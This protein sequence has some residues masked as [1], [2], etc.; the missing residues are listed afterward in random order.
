MA[1]S[2]G[3]EEKREQWKEEGP[4][5]GVGR[6]GRREEGREKWGRNEKKR[7]RL[8]SPGSLLKRQE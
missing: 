8:I 1:E 2:R 6:E 7:D 3:R 4:R 5:K